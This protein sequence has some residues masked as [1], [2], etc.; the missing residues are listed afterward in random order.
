MVS[1][2]QH[3]DWSQFDSHRLGWERASN[4]AAPPVSAWLHGNGTDDFILTGLS[5]TWF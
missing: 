4:T 5:Q 1:G 3:C 2:S